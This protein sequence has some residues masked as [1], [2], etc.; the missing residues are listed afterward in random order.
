MDRKRTVLNQPKKINMETTMKKVT[1]TNEELYYL[2]NLIM[3]INRKLGLIKRRR[4]RR[5]INGW[6]NK[7]FAVFHSSKF[8]LF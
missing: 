5:R 1:L 8:N 7:R 6:R 2:D 4:R 3:E